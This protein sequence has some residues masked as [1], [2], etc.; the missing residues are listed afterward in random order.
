MRHLAADGAIT[1]T[2]VTAAVTLLVG[3]FGGGTVVALMRVNVDKDKIVIDAA[4]GAVVVQ[5]SVITALQA[6]VARLRAEGVELRA[7]VAR[8]RAEGAATAT[9]VTR[10]ERATDDGEGKQP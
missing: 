10:V 4:Q 9:R 1:S 2:L 7:E 5:T 3:L 6:E 8:L